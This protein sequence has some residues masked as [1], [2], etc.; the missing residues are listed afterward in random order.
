[1]L[2]DERLFITLCELLL[3][4][5]FWFWRLRVFTKICNAVNVFVCF[6]IRSWYIGGCLY[7][8]LKTLDCGVVKVMS[9]GN[10]AQLIT[11][12]GLSFWS[13]IEH[14]SPFLL[15]IRKGEIIWHSIQEEKVSWMHLIC[16]A[17][18]FSETVKFVKSQ[19]PVWMLWNEFKVSL[20]YSAGEY[21]TFCGWI[22][23]VLYNT[24]CI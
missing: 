12:S 19:H 17:Q 20:L 10:I 24:A 1:M 15:N 14:K 16:K 2:Q 11:F 4:F 8:R 6:V 22:H 18:P 7:G 9:P 5:S 23:L 13:K 21:I 3:V